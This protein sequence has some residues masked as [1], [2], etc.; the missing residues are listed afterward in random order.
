MSSFGHSGGAVMSELF[1]ADGMVK[2]N[3]LSG[4]ADGQRMAATPCALVAQ[5]LYAR[6]PRLT[7]AAAAYEFLEPEIL[8]SELVRAGFSVQQ[9]TSSFPSGWR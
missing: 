2:Q 5:R 7:G 1:S 9:R 3:M 4:A 8:I 6:A